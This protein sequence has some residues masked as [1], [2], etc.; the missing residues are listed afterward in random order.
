MT[1]ASQTDL[2]DRFGEAELAQRTNRADGL[3]IDTVV[4][5]RALTDADAEID[6][7]LSTR[8]QLPLA[9]TPILLVRL[10]A[11]IARYRLYDDGVPDAVRQRYEDAVALLKRMASGEVQVAGSTVLEVSVQRGIDVAA[12]TP[13]QVFTPGVLARY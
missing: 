13:A 11:D 6:G 9:S 4:L 10:A 5:A 3:T 2:I 12:K 8:Y 1:Y 7:Y